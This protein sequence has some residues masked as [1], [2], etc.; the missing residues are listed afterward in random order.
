MTCSKRIILISYICAIT[1]TVIVVAG[2]FLGFDMSNVT[3]V[4][5]LAW[6][7]VAVSN[8]F[9]YRKAAR[10]NVLKIS[11]TLIKDGKIEAAEVLR[12]VLNQ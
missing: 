12:N 2:S 11:E 1:L 10:E 9:Y 5:A 7:E 8:A 3:T 4:A 6:G